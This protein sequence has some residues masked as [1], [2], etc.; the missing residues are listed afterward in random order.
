VCDRAPDSVSEP[1][2]RRLCGQRGDVTPLVVVTPI[3][4]FMVMLVIQMGMYYHARS[5]MSAAAQ[6][7]ARAM[8]HEGGTSA[9]AYSAANQLLAGSS[10]LLQNELVVVIDG[11]TTVTVTITADMKSVVP[12]FDADLS[13]EASGPKERFRSESGR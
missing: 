4:V 2:A 13:V 1:K 5:V 8:Q 10:S 7:A 6:D 9:D 11:G 12:F 3:L